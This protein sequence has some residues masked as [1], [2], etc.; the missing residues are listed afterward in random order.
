MKTLLLVLVMLDDTAKHKEWMDEAQDLKEDLREALQAK[1]RAKAAEPA[2]RLVQIG[3]QEEDYWRK[4]KLEDI[5][6]LAQKNLEAARDVAAAAKDGYF[7]EALL[8][9]G[10]LEATCRACHDVHPEKR[11]LLRS[12]RATGTGIARPAVAWRSAVDVAAV[13]KSDAP[14]ID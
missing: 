13:R 9:F 6:K 2:A 12:S 3:E 11:L 8:A 14:G 10:R 7:D 4:A 5:V 1:S